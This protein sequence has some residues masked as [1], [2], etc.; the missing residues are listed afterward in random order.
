MSL[1]SPKRR[2]AA[3][4]ALSACGLGA[5]TTT[6]PPATTTAPPPPAPSAVPGAPTNLRL[7]D[8]RD[9]VSLKW[10]YPA[11]AEGPV[12]VSGGRTGQAPRAFQQ[13]RAGSTEY[14]V[15]GLNPQQNYCFTVAVAYSTDRIAAT[16]PTCTSR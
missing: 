3:A 14:V 11:D 2:A 10:A 1:P 13:M 16:A 6:A 4:F 7:A 5:A 15:Y 12:L 9:S 8:N